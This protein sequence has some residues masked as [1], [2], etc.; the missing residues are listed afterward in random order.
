MKDATDRQKDMDELTLKRKEH[1]KMGKINFRYSETKKKL[2]LLQK[3][4]DVILKNLIVY[5]IISEYE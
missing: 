2:K 4:K 1:I 3:L 5:Y